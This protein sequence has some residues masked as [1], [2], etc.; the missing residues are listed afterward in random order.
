MKYEHCKFYPGHHLDCFGRWVGNGKKQWRCEWEPGTS[1][2]RNTYTLFK[3]QGEYCGAKDNI[4]SQNKE[5]TIFQKRDLTVLLVE[6]LKSPNC[7]KAVFKGTPTDLVRCGPPTQSSF[8][9]HS[10]I[11][12][13][14]VV[15]MKH[16]ERYIKDFNLKYTTMGEERKVYAKLFKGK[17]GRVDGLDSS[18]SYM[19]QIKC[20]RNSDCS[21]CPWSHSYII[22]P[23]LKT[24]PTLIHLEKTN[25]PTAKGIRLVTITWQTVEIDKLDGYFINVQKASGEP[26][27]NQFNTSEGAIS[28][29]LSCS[30][31]TVH[32]SAF[33]N[34]SVSPVLTRNIENCDA[35]TSMGAERL[36]VTVHSK[37]SFTVQWDSQLLDSYNCY[38]VEWSRKNQHKT[39]YLSFFED[40]A[41][42]KTVNL[43]ESLKP[44]KRYMLYLHTRPKKETCELK[45]VN[46][47][48]STYGSVQFYYKEGTPIS[49]PTNI[50][51]N[52]VTSSSLVLTWSPIPEDDL[53]GFLLGYIIYYKEY[54][55]RD[56]SAAE[57]VAYVGAET[58]SYVIEDLKPG[59]G[60][61]VEISGFTRAGTGVRSIKG[62]FQT[63]TQVYMK[64]TVIIMI[65]VAAIVLLVVACSIVKRMKAVLWPSL[66]N[67][68]NSNA[69]QKM[70]NSREIEQLKMLQTLQVEEWHTNELL[71][72]K[73]QATVSVPHLV[74]AES[75]VCTRASVRDSDTPLK[76]LL[77]PQ[78]AFTCG[79]TTMEMF[80]QLLTFQSSPSMTQK[81]RE[82]LIQDDVGET[83]PGQ[84]DVGQFSS[85]SLFD[86]STT[87]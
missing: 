70:E 61:N 84:S 81:A 43:T 60:Y 4:S 24:K 28:L 47:S 42:N 2:H 41:S 45:H 63:C 72:I 56:T 76:S 3:Q 71:I 13:L 52:N 38:S 5:I 55:S 80:Q 62:I 26:P 18:Q 58:T 27:K 79:Y 46:G 37:T 23:E 8:L 14:N 30:A 82:R 1:A 10:G 6:N 29:H 25:H 34:V 75:K 15:W 12:D 85:S 22:P 17:N 7:T 83:K 19:V 50:S 32:I 21:Q 53:R 74:T 54:S 69:I 64:D 77:S 87:F 44:Y 11:L 86:L 73:E 35:V 31:F 57:K 40:V 39:E 59:T 49:P 68:E 36:H 65:F 33:N 16:E 78:T 48:E 67:P 9:R 66:P 51:Y 20:D